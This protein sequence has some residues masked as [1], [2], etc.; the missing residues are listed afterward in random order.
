[1]KV[2]AGKRGWE[3]VKVDVGHGGGQE[4][5]IQRVMLQ[6]QVGWRITRSLTCIKTFLHEAPGISMQS[7]E[8]VVV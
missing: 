6:H 3:L 5:M 7:V 8:D 2:D 1:M 4:K